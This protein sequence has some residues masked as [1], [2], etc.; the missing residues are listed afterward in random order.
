[1]YRNLGP[2]LYLYKNPSLSPN[3]GITPVNVFAGRG[4]ESSRQHSL[5]CIQNKDVWTRHRAGKI[6]RKD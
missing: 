5:I 3:Q 1:M 4:R 6:V 2:A